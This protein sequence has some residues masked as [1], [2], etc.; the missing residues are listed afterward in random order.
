[1]PKTQTADVIEIADEIMVELKIPP[2]HKQK[3]YQTA[4]KAYEQGK[5]IKEAIKEH[6]NEQEG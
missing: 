4:Y 2:K 6:W 5:S 3:V 1:M